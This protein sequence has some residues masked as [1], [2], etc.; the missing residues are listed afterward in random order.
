MPSPEPTASQPKTL[1]TPLGPIPVW[2]ARPACEGCEG[3]GEVHEHER[4]QTIPVHR[5]A[6]EDDGVVCVTRRC[7]QC[8]GSGVAEE[9]ECW[10]CDRVFG[11]A[12][13]YATTAPSPTTVSTE[14]ICRDCIARGATL[15]R[16]DELVE[17][18][19]ASHAAEL[20]DALEA[21]VRG[22]E[23]VPPLQSPPETIRAW[24]T[25][26]A[27]LLAIHREAL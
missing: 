20:R 13:L 4:V 17:A 7:E 9:A 27:L 14:S 8:G 23:A 22:I 24:S 3:E 26:R 12:D 18:L 25:S 2:P 6:C 11:A 5:M 10:E 16:S 15:P 1:P 19:L 21:C